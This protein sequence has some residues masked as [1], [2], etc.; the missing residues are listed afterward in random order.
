MNISALIEKCKKR[1]EQAEKELFFRFAPKILSICRRYTADEDLAQDY[2]QECFM[3]LFKNIKQYQPEKGPFEGWMYRLCTNRILQAFRK[4]K[5]EPILEFWEELPDQE[6]PEEQFEFIEEELLL[7]AVRQLPVG[8][9]EV[10]NLAV[11]E[12]WSHQEI[13][14]RLGITESTSRSQLSRAKK[15]LKQFL[16]PLISTNYEKRL[17]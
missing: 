2:L 9:R 1:N 10:L 12:G 16:Q 4:T 8:Y 3:T 11:F 15:M 5:R 6:L 14:I 7:S 13:A 17:A